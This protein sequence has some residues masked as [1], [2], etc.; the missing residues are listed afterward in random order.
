MDTSTAVALIPARA[1]SSRVPGKNIRRLGGHPLIA[2]AIAAARE[3]GVF[4][5]VM[6]STDAEEIA[7]ISRYYG[8]SVPFLRPQ[9]YATGDSPDI[10]WLVYTL[11]ELR[12]MGQQFSHCSILRPTSPFRSA[13]TIRRAWQELSAHPQADS[14]RAVEKA[15]QHPGKMWIRNGEYMVPVLPFA[16]PRQPWHSTPYQE[17]PEVYAQN[18]SLEIARVDAVL[19]TNTLT[20][21][22]VLP[23]FTNPIEGFDIN[24]PDEWAAAEVMLA[25]GAASLPSV[26]TTPWSS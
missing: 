4:D 9:E 15:R 13:A 12:A 17:L 3:S 20:G 25:Q 8:A 23:F 18:A 26:N 10:E 11:K 22:V 24:L 6:V 21:S 5:E 1:G 16:T 2:Y 7:E 14:L 19:Q